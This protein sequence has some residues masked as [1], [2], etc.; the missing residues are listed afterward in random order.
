LFFKVFYNSGFT[1]TLCGGNWE[2]LPGASNAFNDTGSS[3]ARLGCCLHGTFM[4]QPN[5]DPFTQ[6]TACASCPVGNYSGMSDDLNC[7]YTAT[8]CPGTHAY[9]VEPASCRVPIPDCTYAVWA[10]PGCKVESCFNVRTCGIRQ[11]V[12]TYINSGSTGSYGPIEDWDTSFVTDMSWLFYLK[13]GFNANISA[14]QVG[15]VTN[16][17]RS[18]YTLPLPLQDRVF[19][20]LFLLLHFQCQ[21]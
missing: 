9:A 11:A 12:D 1:R 18:T 8:T 5:L 2:S 7:P 4:A 14:W 21:H 3:T 10:D 17:I 13:R 16:M 20:W 15:K 19:F 6:A